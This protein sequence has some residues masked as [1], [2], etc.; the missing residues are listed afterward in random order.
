MRF[1][2]DENC[3][4]EMILSSDEI[5]LIKSKAK[6]LRKLCYQFGFFRFDVMADYVG[7]DEEENEFTYEQVANGLKKVLPFVEKYWNKLV[8]EEFL[9]GLL[10]E[11]EEH[12]HSVTVPVLDSPLSADDICEEIANNFDCLDIADALSKFSDRATLCKVYEYLKAQEK[13]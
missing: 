8:E 10:T 3:I 13:D 7:F 4:E 9:L 11:I 6:E 2:Y 5:K 1:K 12:I